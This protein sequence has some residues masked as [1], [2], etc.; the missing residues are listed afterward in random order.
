VPLRRRVLRQRLLV[1][2]APSQAFHE[3]WTC[4]GSPAC[5]VWAN[6]DAFEQGAFAKHLLA[7]PTWQPYITLADAGLHNAPCTSFTSAESRGAL[8]CHFLAEYKDDIKG[9]VG[10][11]TTAEG[12]VEMAVAEVVKA[13][14]AKATR[15]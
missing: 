4:S 3:R 7:A 2:C 14:A 8:A 15:N 5:K 10:E 6:S 13:R 11:A 9:Y 1:S 12:A